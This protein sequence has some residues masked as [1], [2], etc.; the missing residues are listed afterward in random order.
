M[1]LT[2]AVI[3]TVSPANGAGGV[4]FISADD[5]V[6]SAPVFAATFIVLNALLFESFTSDIVSSG[7]IFT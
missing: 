4:K 1:F 6:K 3:V 7:S 2:L 5:N